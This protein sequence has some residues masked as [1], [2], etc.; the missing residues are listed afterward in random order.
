MR[1]RTFAYAGTMNIDT[2]KGPVL[3]DTASAIDAAARSI[4][5]SAGLTA[6]TLRRVAS[7][8]GLPPADIASREPSMGALAGRTF[9]DLARSEFDRV[10][11]ELGPVDNDLHFLAQLIDTMM[12]SEHSLSKTIW[13]DAWS[14]G[15]HNQFVAQAARDSMVLWQDFLARRLRAGAEAGAFSVFDAELAAEQFFAMI[16]STTAY[17][18]VG[19]LDDATRTRLV[20]STL[21]TALSLPIGTLTRQDA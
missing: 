20:A 16:D 15:R 14:V 7:I 19:Y 12:T 8:S 5:T 11:A 18:L 10:S 13:A 17:A 3:V 21:E 4:A 2:A 1:P 6:I 9:A